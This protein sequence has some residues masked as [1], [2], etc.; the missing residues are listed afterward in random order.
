MRRCVFADGDQSAIA[1]QEIVEHQDFFSIGRTVIRAHQQVAV[2]SQL[3]P[4]VFAHV[5]V[6]PVDPRIGKAHAIGEVT[7]DRLDPVERVLESNAVP[8]DAR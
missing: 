6:V 7:C 5:R 2:Q 3:L 1:D 4:D 8:V